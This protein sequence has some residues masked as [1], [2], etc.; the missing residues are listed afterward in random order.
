VGKTYKV[1]LHGTYSTSSTNP[2]GL[3]I[4]IKLG[5]TVVAQGSFTLAANKTDVAFECRNEFTCRATGASGTV[6]SMGIMRSADNIV[7]KLNNGT[8]PTSITL[9]TSQ[10][11]NITVQLTNS[12]SGNSVS[13]YLVLLEAMN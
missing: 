4:K 10:S 13:A 5:S 9:S 12:V 3:T 11:L 8:S 6:F 7:T 1:V 2:A